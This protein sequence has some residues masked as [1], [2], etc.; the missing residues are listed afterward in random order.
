MIKACINLKDQ[1]ASNFECL[2]KFHSTYEKV[3]GDS[4]GDG[5]DGIDDKPNE[6]GVTLNEGNTNEENV[7]PKDKN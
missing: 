2:K 1:I 5:T 6:E 7:T 3:L 4:T